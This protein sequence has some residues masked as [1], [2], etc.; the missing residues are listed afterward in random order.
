MSVFEKGRHDS[1]LLLLTLTCIWISNSTAVE[2]KGT[3]AAASQQKQG[4]ER[5]GNGSLNWALKQ[6]VTLFLSLL[7]FYR[8]NFLPARPP[9]LPWLQS[10]LFMGWIV[11]VPQWQKLMVLSAQSLTL[12]KMC[13][14]TQPELFPHKV[15]VCYVSLKVPAIASL[16]VWWWSFIGKIFLSQHVVWGW[17]WPHCLFVLLPV[18]LKCHSIKPIKRQLCL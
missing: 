6:E 13:F 2:L 18:C 11:K 14:V 12:W 16:E 17:F 1:C 10:M 15:W 4:E 3:V 7:C 9:L 5:E 8:L